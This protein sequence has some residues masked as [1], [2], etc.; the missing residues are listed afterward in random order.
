[1]S[2]RGSRW[3]A[4]SPALRYLPGTALPASHHSGSGEVEGR[5]AAHPNDAH[6]PGL[7]LGSFAVYLTLR[8]RLLGSVGAST[9]PV[10]RVP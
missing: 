9:R 5:L 7:T 2:G 8:P 4:C 10:G 6:Q 1:V 3:C